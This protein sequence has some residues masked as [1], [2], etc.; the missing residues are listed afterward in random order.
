MKQFS[1]LLTSIILGVAALLPVNA[2]GATDQIK[3]DSIA[4][5][6]KGVKTAADSIRILYDVF[7]LCDQ[8]NKADIGWKIL[9]MAFR[10]KDYEAISDMAPQVAVMARRDDAS[11]EKLLN[12]A[13]II[14]DE[15][16][17]RGTEV[18]VKVQQAVNEAT[19]LSE[20]E[21]HDVLMKY[22]KEDMTPKNDIYED[23]LDLYRVVVFLGRSSQGSMYLEYLD[24]LESLIKEL[25][26]SNYALRNLYFTTAAIFHSQ[27]DNP[28]KS[29]E[30]DRELLKIIPKLEAKYQKM[31]R[32]YRNYDRYYY[33]SYRRMLSNYPVLSPQEIDDIYYKCEK[34][35]ERDKEVA[36]DFNSK[37]RPTAYLY[38]SQKDYTKALP[39]LKQALTYEKNGSTRQQL[40]ALIVEAADAV[41]DKEALLSA[42]KEY[43]SIL[44]EKQKLNSALAYSEL[45]IRYDINQLKAEKERLTLQKRDL[46]IAS[47]EKIISVAL[48]SVFALAIILMLLY[49]SH[50]RLRH[51]KRDLES[52]NLKLHKSMRELLDD[53]LPANTC[54]VHDLTPRRESVGV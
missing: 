31:G 6:L 28:T 22:A 33:I 47:D 43:N 21:R 25:P 37:G 23:V 38:L 29:I 11:Y 48:I 1:V 42:L 49:R 20:K 8:R 54:D 24:R 3:A 51:K 35:A 19:Y 4:S 12:Y 16:M 52:E 46:E 18:F 44:T 26:E 2:V 10:S 41:G 15:G 5:S 36:G 13:A 30:C 17:R 34:L 32:K 9:D 50:F 45:R 7:D 53:G 27:N 14:P 39:F 40:L